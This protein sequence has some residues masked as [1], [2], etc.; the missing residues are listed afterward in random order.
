[1]EDYVLYHFEMYE[2]DNQV[3]LMTVSTTYDCEGEAFATHL[4]DKIVAFLN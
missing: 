2:Y 3:V 4:V 1:M